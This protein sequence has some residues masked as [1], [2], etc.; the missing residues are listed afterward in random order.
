MELD[1]KCVYAPVPA[2]TAP[3][4]TAPIIPAAAAPV[5]TAT[6]V[7]GGAAI[8][9]EALPMYCRNISLTIGTTSPSSPVRSIMT[10]GFARTYQYRLVASANPAG[11]QLIHLANHGAKY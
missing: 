10:T 3:V 11:S 9:G 1:L 8:D 6:D 4:A 5:P 7:T 2:I